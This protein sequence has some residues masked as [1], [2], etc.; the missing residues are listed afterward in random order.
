MYAMTRARWVWSLDQDPDTFLV[1][2]MALLA[3]FPLHAVRMS[4]WRCPW[5]CGDG[6][7]LKRS[8]SELPLAG[9]RGRG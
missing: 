2:M 8:K 9:W 6:I 1:V 3:F 7:G 5:I 4:R